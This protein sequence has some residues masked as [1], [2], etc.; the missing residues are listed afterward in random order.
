MPRRHRCAST[1]NG[2]DLDLR[3]VRAF[4]AVAEE[5]H[6]G[7]AAAALHVAQPALSRQV[8]RLEAQLG[9]R[10]L[11]RTSRS[12]ELT[13]AGGAFLPDARRLLAAADAAVRRFRDGTLRVGF[14]PGLQ[15]TAAVR[16]VR[17]RHPDVEVELRRLDWEEQVPALREGLIDVLLG[18][19]PLDGDGLCVEHL[20]EEPRVVLLPADH[21]LAGKEDISVQ[22]IAGEPMVRHAATPTVWDVY[23]AVDPPGGDGVVWGPVV[24]GLE[25]KLEQVATGQAVTILPRSLG[26]AHSREDVRFVELRDAPPSHVV[27]AWRDD[28]RAG[29]LRAAFLAAARASLR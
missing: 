23:W 22:D 15:P 2:V 7:R 28:G 10:L 20:Y 9:V 11:D 21:P 26:T 3:L 13:G 25:E 14:M 17:G 4:V 16:A 1:V 6:F 24:R 19:L 12:V 8:R 27:M 5:R 18:R 29:P